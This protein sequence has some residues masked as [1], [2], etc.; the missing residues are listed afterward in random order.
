[1]LLPSQIKALGDWVQFEGS[2]LPMHATAHRFTVLIPATLSGAK[3]ET[4]EEQMRK[5]HLVKRVVDLEKPAHT[6]CDFR[7]Y[8]NLFRLEEVRLG[9][10]TLLGLGSR[11]PQLHPALIVGEGYVGES[12]LGVPQPEKYSSRFVLD[13]EQLKKSKNKKG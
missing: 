2:V 8:W 5:M 11:D 3:R 13:S 1:M 7:Y 12:H 9:L 6:I 10:D 4:P